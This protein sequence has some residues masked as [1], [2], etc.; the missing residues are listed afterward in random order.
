M[1]KSLDLGTV[2]KQEK[3]SPGEAP[4]AHSTKKLDDTFGSFYSRTELKDSRKPE[5]VQKQEV[6]TV[7]KEKS[8]TSFVSKSALYYDKTQSNP[9][10]TDTMQEDPAVDSLQDPQPYNPEDGKEPKDKL[11]KPGKLSGAQASPMNA[12]AINASLAAAN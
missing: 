1:M 4:R 7:Q 10:T 5:I 2:Y 3:P 11:K 12:D 9:A 6:P 8:V